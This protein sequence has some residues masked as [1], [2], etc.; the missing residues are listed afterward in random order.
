MAKNKGE[1]QKG[2]IEAKEVVKSPSALREEE[3]LKFWDENNIFQE[4]ESK[5]DANGNLKEA[6]TFYDGPPF[7]T[8]LPHHGHILAGTIKDAIPRYQTMRGKSVFR[9]WGWDCHGLPLEN[10]I[11]KE[12][13]LKTKKDIEELGIDKFN[14]SARDSVLRYAEDWKRVIPRMGRWVDMENDY[15]TMDT[16][17]TESV[18]WAF[19]TLYDKGLIYQGFKSMLLCPRCE[20]TLSNNEVA[21]GYK[22]ITD[23]SVTIKFELKDEPGTFLL[24]WTTTPWTL[25]GNMAIAVNPEIEYVKARRGDECFILAKEKISVLGDGAEILES[26]KGEK[27]VGKSY[28]PIFD[29]YTSK[30]FPNKENA[31]KVYP[32]SYVTVETGTGIVHLAPAF[33]A[34]DM[35]LAQTCKIPIIHHVDIS[36]KFKPEITDFAGHTA[37]PKDDSPEGDHQASDILV[38]KNLAHRGIL[39]AKEKIIH[40]YP[41]CWRCDTPLLN[42]ASISWFVK[43]ADIKD[44][45]IAENKK[46]NWVPKEIRDGRFGKMLESAPDWAISRSRY[47]GAP[48]PVWQ[49]EQCEERKVFG[50]YKELIDA[51]I[52]SG[53]SYF[54]MRHG[55]ADSNVL[56]IVDSNTPGVAHL[57]ELGKEQALQSAKELKGKKID[58]IFTSPFLRTQE[59]AQIVSSEL[60]LAENS[61]IVD[62]RLGEINTGEFDGKS[63]DDY[64]SFF[65]SYEERFTKTPSGGESLFQMKGRLGAFLYEIDANYKDKNILIIGHEYVGWLLQAVAKGS[66][67]EGSVSLWSGEG[68]FIK[69]GEI[70]ELFFKQLP[71]S[72]RFELDV[73]RPYIDVIK[74]TCSC[75]G[76]LKRV[77]EVFD[78]WFESGSM[79]YGQFHYPFEN[80]DQFDPKKNIGF[81]ADFIAEGIDQTRG[82]FNSTLVLGVAL[83]DKSPYKHV[84]TNGL[85]LAEDGQKMSKKLK[86]YP[87]PMD[88][89]ERFGADALRYYLL[90]S[91]IV[92]G[93]DLNFSEKSIDEINK[94][95]LLRLDNV[96]SFYELY[97]EDSIG[98]SNSSDNVLDQWIVARLSNLTSDITAGMDAYELDRATRPMMAFV[99]DLS[100]WYL[101]RSRDRLKGED[102]A[103]KQKALATIHFVLKE[104]SKLM[105]PFMPFFAEYLFLK[106]KSENDPES[107]HLANWPTAERVINSQIIADMDKVRD[108]VTLGLEARSKAKIV[109]RQPLGSLKIKNQELKGKDELLELLKDEVNVK[110]ISF[111]E[112]LETEVGLDTAIT[113]PLK[114]EG[115]IRELTRGIQELRKQKGLN[116]SDI[117]SLSISANEAGN[118]LLKKFEAQIKRVVLAEIIKYEDNNGSPVAAGEFEFTVDIK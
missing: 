22:D 114:E 4:S 75:G 36:G 102:V 24:A 53:N 71:H 47:W 92:R 93:E 11:E 34:E 48:L 46:I 7:A 20:T 112:R 84:I 18:W 116:P 85:V 33:G 16:T 69:T 12:L 109:V 70:Q 9:R 80:L 57:T 78:C 108:L 41:H 66:D 86:N 13:G 43:V 99:D 19:K 72:E 61:V 38:I 100:T 105:A 94:K 98:P 110:E 68:E 14:Q 27:V 115:D 103:D 2:P 5:T 40:S 8:G 64:H 10:I 101:R 91:Q 49:C 96:L 117:I 67:N 31:W 6:F 111:D 89:V 106:L 39:F 59:T 32:A 29:Y 42:Y 107:V 90:S 65:K 17:Y 83:F 54:V 52:G 55:Q 87:D 62:S 60:G 3:I 51:Q 45:L 56:K 77:P 58:L 118:N 23:I 26:F 79:P 44:K 35:E 82:W 50:S 73:H 37:K 63:V 1:N 97:R 104:F 76:N 25:P 95:L 28:K 81:P 88:V 15:K 74:I 113:A 30:D 21:L